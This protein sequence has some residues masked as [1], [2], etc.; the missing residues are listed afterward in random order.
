MIEDA[1]AAQ[2]STVAASRT[3]MATAASSGGSRRWFGPLLAILSLLLMATLLEAG[4]RVALSAERQQTLPHFGIGEDLQAR[5]AWIDWQKH[6]DRYGTTSYPSSF[7]QPDPDLGWKIKPN[8]AARHVKPGAYEV[9]V[10]TNERG[11][12]GTAPVALAKT[13]GRTRIGVFGCSQTF[14]ETVDDDETY[15]ARLAAERPDAEFLNFGVRGYGTDQMLL[16]Y[17]Q[18]AAAYDLDVVVLAFAFYH[19]KRN[20]AGFLF[21]AKPYF[22]LDSNGSLHLHGVPVPSPDEFEAQDS[23]SYTWPL[24]D[25]SVLLRW[26]WDRGRRLRERGFYSGTGYPWHLTEALIA[27]FVGEA[28]AEGSKVV[29]MNIDEEHPALEDELQA[30]A[31][32]LDVGFVNLG[33][34]LR[35]AGENGITYTLADDNH[36]NAIGHGMVADRLEGFLCERKLLAGCV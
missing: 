11:M 32:R 20:A 4:L 5:L 27:R 19:M 13:P 23:S 34:E 24:A 35:Y 36:W 16:Y 7:D 18:E 28:R 22:D 29:L 9:S 2:F 1:K 30:L 26:L 8:V 21:Y 33:P 25:R 14:G 12:R 10:H 3:A 15:V 17:E 31:D 6:R